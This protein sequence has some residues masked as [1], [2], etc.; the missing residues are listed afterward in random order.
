MDIKFNSTESSEKLLWITKSMPRNTSHYDEHCSK[1]KVLTPFGIA[2]AS[3]LDVPNCSA[4]ICHERA[5]RFACFWIALSSNLMAVFVGIG[6]TKTQRQFL[7]NPWQ[8]FGSFRSGHI[9]FFGRGWGGG[10]VGCDAT[11]LSDAGARILIF[12]KYFVFVIL[13]LVF[14][15]WSQGN[16]PTCFPR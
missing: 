1:L 5:E 12:W 9:R 2:P 14:Q 8:S 11:T 16:S 7:Q 6:I 15:E 3:S 4:S 10:G 13:G